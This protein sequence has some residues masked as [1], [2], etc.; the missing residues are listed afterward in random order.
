MFSSSNLS[1]STMVAY[2]L[3]KV[4]KSYLK[5]QWLKRNKEISK[6]VLRQCFLPTFS[7]FLHRPSPFPFFSTYSARIIKENISGWTENSPSL[8]L[9]ITKR[10]TYVYSRERPGSLR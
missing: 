2:N 8:S 10:I 7:P 5:L 6:Q 9:V 3:G 1:L 4:E